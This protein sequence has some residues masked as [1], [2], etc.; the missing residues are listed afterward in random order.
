MRYDDILANM[1]KRFDTLRNELFG[2]F[3]SES[4]E[5]GGRMP[6]VD[7]ADHEKEFV[8]T[9]ELPGV[10]KEDIDLQI[11]DNGVRIHAEKERETEK[12][13]REFVRHER[14]ASSYDRYLSLPAE[15]KAEEAKAT[16]KNG[17]L[18]VT[19]PKAEPEKSVGHAIPIE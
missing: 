10:D 7:L 8:L 17:V 6:A 13:G 4:M 19:L 18:E 1:E 5:L 2:R 11:L 9:A 14:S 16:F 3:G 12:K 15:V